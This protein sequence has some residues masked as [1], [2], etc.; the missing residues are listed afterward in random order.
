LKSGFGEPFSYREDDE[1]VAIVRHRV[2]T[3][4]PARLLTGTAVATCLAASMNGLMTAGVI[5]RALMLVVLAAIGA[6]W[7]MAPRVVIIGSSGD[8]AI[9]FDAH[10]QEIVAPRRLDLYGNEVEDAIGDYRLDRHGS[11]Y[12][13]HSPETALAPLPAPIL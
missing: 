9:A 5:V 6:A 7:A 1:T 2:A 13:R 10:A 12:E 8:T 4:V 3:V 11:I